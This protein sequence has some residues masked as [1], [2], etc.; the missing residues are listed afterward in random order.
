MHESN[1]NS[2][3]IEKNKKALLRQQLLD[4]LEGEYAEHHELLEQQRRNRLD[5]S[6][7]IEQFNNE[8]H[9]STHL[10]ESKYNL[11]IS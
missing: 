1:M 5:S 10:E 3:D 7:V 4:D 6:T 8:L 11:P 2:K 9:E